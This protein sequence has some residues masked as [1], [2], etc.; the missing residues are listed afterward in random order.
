MSPDWNCGGLWMAGVMRT[1]VNRGAHVLHVRRF[2]FDLT[3]CFRTSTNST[4]QQQ[5]ASQ[6]GSTTPSSTIPYIG[7]TNPLVTSLT[8]NYTHNYT[9]NR[10]EHHSYA[11]M[12]NGPERQTV[13]MKSAQISLAAL[14]HIPATV[15]ATRFPAQSQEGQGEG[16]AFP[17]AM[18]TLI[19]QRSKC[20]SERGTRCACAMDLNSKHMLEFQYT[21][22]I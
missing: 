19:I 11:T 2:F 21:E 9:H 16:C 15:T 7:T 22:G 20:S 1:C 14:T 17:H 4:V 18:D 12:A 8:Y 6:A 3:A 10:N 5:V 13:E